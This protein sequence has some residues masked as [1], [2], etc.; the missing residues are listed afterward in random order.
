MAVRR[1]P[2]DREM[3]DGGSGFYDEE[4]AIQGLGARDEFGNVL[5]NFSN[6]PNYPVPF[7][8]YQ[9]GEI[10]GN[11]TSAR[12]LFDKRSA[13][14]PM[15]HEP[16]EDRV[17]P[18]GMTVQ[19]EEGYGGEGGGDQ[20]SFSTPSQAR[21]PNPISAMRPNPQVT[22]RVSSPGAQSAL[23]ADDSGGTPLF[24]RAGGLMGGGKGVLGTNEGGPSPTDMMLSLLR[25]FR[26]GA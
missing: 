23:F 7:Q 19:G 1:T 20:P 26:G 14:T 22:R 5:P 17:L 3:D 24:G 6:D 18:M 10:I 13:A 15:R 11:Q 9:P 12:E 16:Q 21:E 8:D 25:M 2:I 4:G